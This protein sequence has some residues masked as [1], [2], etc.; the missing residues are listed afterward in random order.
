MGGSGAKG[1][2]L[3]GPCMA[4]QLVHTVGGG[5]PHTH[6][7]QTVGGW[8]QHGQVSPADRGD[9]GWG[10][11]SGASKPRAELATAEGEGWGV[12]PSG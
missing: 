3:G 10:E 11:G 5:T 1:G 4:C 2:L 6:G 12:V 7:H 8:T 9:P